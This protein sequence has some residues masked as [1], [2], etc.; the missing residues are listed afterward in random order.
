MVIIALVYLFWAVIVR[1]I[2]ACVKRCTEED[3]DLEHKYH[4]ENYEKDFYSCVDFR[5]LMDEFKLASQTQKKSKDMFDQ[6]DLKQLPEW[7]FEPYYKWLEKKQIDIK[8]AI[9]QLAKRQGPDKQPYSA[10]DP[11]DDFKGV[12]EDLMHKEMEGKLPDCKIKD[13]LKTY[14]LLQNNDYKRLTA[15]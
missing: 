1:T 12:I 3:E 2:R 13:D 14:E 10:K 4:E 8:S 11:K 15:Y 6:G 5:T 7:K 9:E